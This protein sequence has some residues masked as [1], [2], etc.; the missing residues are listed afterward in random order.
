MFNIDLHQ[1]QDGF[2]LSISFIFSMCELNF[3]QKGTR[4]K[5]ELDLSKPIISNFHVFISLSGS[6][7]KAS[8]LEPHILNLKLNLLVSLSNHIW[9]CLVLTVLL[10]Q[11]ATSPKTQDILHFN[12]SSNFSWLPTVL[13]IYI[14]H[15]QSLCL[16]GLIFKASFPLIIFHGGIVPSSFI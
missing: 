13:Y 1:N 14:I 5:A 2:S 6:N 10:T 12:V 8:Y 4:S 9:F 7:S 3:G 11:M 16:F 15:Y